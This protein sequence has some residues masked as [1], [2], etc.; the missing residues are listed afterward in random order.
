MRLAGAAAAALL[1]LAACAHAPPTSE[2]PTPPTRPEERPPGPQ[3]EP[4]QPT[5]EVGLAS[6]YGRAFHGRRTASGARYDMHA[7][8]CAHPSAPF[9]TRLRVT[10]LDNGRSV[11]VVVNDRGPFA[12]GRVVD[13]SLEAA[14]RLGIVSRGLARVRVERIEE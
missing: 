7:L 12:R 8:T 2:P 9:G 6:Y 13:L 14:R 1:V 11:D 4:E 3:A 5:G 10:D